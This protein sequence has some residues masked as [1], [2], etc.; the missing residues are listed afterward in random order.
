[1]QRCVLIFILLLST[2][3]ISW[4]K[5]FQSDTKLGLGLVALLGGSYQVGEATTCVL[6]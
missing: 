5:I 1:M 3:I 6:F 4:G 2:D